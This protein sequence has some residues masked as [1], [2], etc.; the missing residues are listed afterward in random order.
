MLHIN[1]KSGRK[2]GQIEPDCTN[3]VFKHGKVKKKTTNKK[4]MEGRSFI[5]LNTPSRISDTTRYW[6][7]CVQEV[8]TY[9]I[10]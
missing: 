10:K 2:S 3:F 6:I 1:L 8:V 7:L 4:E 5:T 9:S